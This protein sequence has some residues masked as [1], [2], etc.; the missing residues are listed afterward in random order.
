MEEGYKADDY[1]YSSDSS[2]NDDIDNISLLPETKNKP[3]RLRRRKVHLF[4]ERSLGF[5]CKMCSKT[6]VYTSVTA[7]LL[8]TVVVI[9]VFVKPSLS[10]EFDETIPEKRSSKGDKG[11]KIPPEDSSKKYLDKDGKEFPWQ[12]IRLP[13]NLV[14]E[15]YL[16]QLHPNLTTFKFK[17]FVE[18]LLECKKS[19]SYVY[20]HAKNMDLTEIKLYKVDDQANKLGE[21]LAIGEKWLESPKLEMYA[22]KVEQKLKAGT[23][24]I[25]YVEFKATLADKLAGFYKSS[26]KNKKGEIR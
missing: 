23:R 25:L 11:S 4:R 7:V 20:F 18:M 5:N 10:E 14:P 2:F 13:S 16:V 19:T 6:L 17:G 1:S 21:S 22:V 9:S 3:S 12:K 15:K 26:Y 24:Y 8:L